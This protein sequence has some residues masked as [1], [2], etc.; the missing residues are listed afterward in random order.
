MTPNLR[1]AV[2]AIIS[3]ADHPRGSGGIINDYFLIRANY[4]QPRGELTDYH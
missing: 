2:R 3:A 1:R 4:F